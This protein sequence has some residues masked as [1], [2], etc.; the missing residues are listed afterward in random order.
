MNTLYTYDECISL[1]TTRKPKWKRVMWRVFAI[2]FTITEGEE[3]GN[4]CFAFAREQENYSARVIS[5]GVLL[6]L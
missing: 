1:S 5:R 2:V 4:T 6:S 3:D